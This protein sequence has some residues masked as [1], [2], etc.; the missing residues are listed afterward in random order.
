MNKGTITLGGLKKVEK[1]RKRRMKQRLKK[2]LG[3][4]NIHEARGKRRKGPPPP[5]RSVTFVDN[6]AGG[7]LAKRMQ[8]AEDEL[9]EATGYRIRNAES[10]GSALGVLLPS[11]NPWGPNDCERADCIICKQ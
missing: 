6:T 4:M 9:G 10:A 11:T 5:T 1:A 2:K 7:E 3:S 8:A